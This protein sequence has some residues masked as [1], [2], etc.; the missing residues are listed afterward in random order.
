LDTGNKGDRLTIDY[1][2]LLDGKPY[3]NNQAQGVTVEL[4]SNG[5]IEGFEEGLLGVKASETREL[6]LF[7]PNDWRFEKLAGK[8]V[9]FSITVKSVEEKQIAECD[10]QFAKKIGAS[11]GTLSAIRDRV[12]ENLE[13]Q[14]GFMVKEN[15]KKRVLDKLLELN[16]MDLPKALIEHEVSLLHEDLHR[17]KNDKANDACQHQGLEEEAKK[18]VHLSLILR[19]IVKQENLT[20]DREK[21]REKILELAKNFGNTELIESLYY[22]SKELIAEVQN[23]V[24]VEEIINLILAKASIILKSVTMEDFLREA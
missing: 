17:K 19:K 7:F 10:E 1:T 3:E 9:H 23:S 8:P 14:L 6:D 11:A 2:S 15:I 18:R 4:G 13:K 16:D 12:R 24:L 20:A 5:F 22:E 21:V